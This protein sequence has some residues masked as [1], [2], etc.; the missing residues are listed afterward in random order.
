MRRVIGPFFLVGFVFVS[1][2][3]GCVSFEKVADPNAEISKVYDV[4]LTKDEI[5]DL[6]LQFIAENFKSAKSVLEYQ[7]KEAGRIIGNGTTSI[8]DGFMGRPA[9]FTMVIDIKDGRYRVS[10]K[11]LEYQA[12]TQVPW[13][14]I[15]AKV[16]YDDM[17]KQLDS[18]GDG[19]YSY[20]QQ[21]KD[22]LDF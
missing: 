15:T 14:P 5:Y 13:G 16:P 12:A 4:A 10:Y 2:F 22:N 17:V 21:G 11:S 20:L 8:N 9:S 3:A 1:L 19:L 18:L 7:D 6:A